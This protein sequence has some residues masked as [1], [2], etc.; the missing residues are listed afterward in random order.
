MSENT[1]TQ[2]MK[3]ADPN[4]RTIPLILLTLEKGCATDKMTLSEA[5]LKAYE[6][7]LMQ[8]HVERLGAQE[9]FLARLRMESRE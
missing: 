4:H 6:A 8:G 2:T 3:L 7:G 5:L 1:P 9:R